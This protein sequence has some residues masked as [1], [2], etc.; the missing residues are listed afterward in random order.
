[1]LI[2]CGVAIVRP[3]GSNSRQEKIEKRGNADFNEFLIGL[4]IK[5]KYYILLD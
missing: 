5:Q 1:M 2:D 3:A 4:K